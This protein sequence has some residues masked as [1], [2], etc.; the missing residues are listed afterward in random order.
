MA[1]FSVAA[2]LAGSLRNME[3]SMWFSGAL[4][5]AAIVGVSFSSAPASAA[6]Y[7]WTLSGDD[8]LSGSGT[9]TLSSTMTGGGYLVTAMTGSIDSDDF[10][11]KSVL[12]TFESAAVNNII[13]YP[14]LQGGFVVD[15]FGL[16]IQ[17]SDT[18]Q[19]EIG[20]ANGNPGNYNVSCCGGGNP[21]YNYELADFNLG[22]VD[23]TPEASTWAMMIAALPVL[24][25]LGAR[26]ARR[27]S[28]LAAPG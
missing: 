5:F 17:L 8:G 28:A 24:G 2:D 19:I 11:T 21:V 1:N 26:G 16:G 7:D 12:G 9:I 6:V 20:A 23:A 4:A 3:R 15:D 22:P 10:T 25:F 27:A 18:Y 13:Y 14:T